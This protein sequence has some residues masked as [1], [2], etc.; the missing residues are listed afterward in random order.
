MPHLITA[1]TCHDAVL[2]A[3]GLV[4]TEGVIVGADQSE[5]N[6]GPYRYREVSDVLVHITEPRARIVHTS[7]FQLDR[8]VLRALW[9]LAGRRDVA[10]LEHLFPRIRTFADDADYLTGSATG[11]RLREPSR[12]DEPHGRTISQLD[13]VIERLSSYPTSRRA[14]A[15]TYF[16][17][18]ASRHSKDIPCLLSLTWRLRSAGLTC[19]SVMRA[20]NVHRLLHYNLFECT[21]LTD[22]VAVR[23]AQPVSAYQH[24][25]VSLHAYEPDWGTATGHDSDNSDV[26]AAMP[27]PPSDFE[28]FEAAEAVYAYLQGCFYAARRGDETALRRQWDAAHA[29]APYWFALFCVAVKT[30]ITRLGDHGLRADYA[31]VLAAQ[32]WIPRT[33]IPV[34]K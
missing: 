25:V 29:L 1:N 9:I 11:Y 2:A 3:R 28:P 12:G 17:S 18:D 30:C 10:E 5:S 16:P 6:L 33:F 13:G 23:L 15:V 19:T 7:D 20:N 22:C 21:L 24:F 27:G 4:R 32:S 14:T 31:D 34:A 26:G 8:A